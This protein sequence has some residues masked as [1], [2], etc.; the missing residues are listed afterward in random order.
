MG[1]NP[2]DYDFAGYA[3]MND[4]LCSDG[5]IIKRDAFKAQDGSRIPLLWNHDHQD[6]SDVIGHAD[7]ENRSDGVY[8][9]C[10]FNNSENAKMAKEIVQHGDISSL[11]IY[12]NKLKQMGNEVLHGVIRELSLVH[13]GANDGAQIDW[14]LAHSD[15]QRQV[16]DLFTTVIYLLPSCV[17]QMIRQMHQRKEIQKCQITIQAQLSSMATKQ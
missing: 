14:V 11:S 12:A 10:K 17:I 1:F 6:I 7:L 3:T 4:I 9:Y 16:K 8:A 13:A 15:D 5:R 2:N